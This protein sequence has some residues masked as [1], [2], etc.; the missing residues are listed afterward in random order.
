MVFFE[1]CNLKARRIT[2]ID[3]INVFA[4]FKSVME[5]VSGQIRFS[6]GIPGQSHLS[7]KGLS[8]EKEKDQG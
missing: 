7:G 8:R 1:I 4:G 5:F 3:G 6:I 2:H